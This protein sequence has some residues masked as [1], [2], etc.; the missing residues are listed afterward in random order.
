M[1]TYSGL[2]GGS[3]RRV[4]GS[5]AIVLAAFWLPT[6]GT[7]GLAQVVP[8]QAL[9]A[10]GAPQFRVDPFWP[11][12]LPNRWSMQQVTGISVDTQDTVW[13]LNRPNAPEM[14]EISAEGT[15]SPTLCCIKGPELIQLDQQGNVL[16]SWGGAGHPKW[17]TNSQTVIADS[18]GNIWISGTAA[19]DSI[20][21]YSREGTVLWDFDHRPPAEAAEMPEIN[22]ETSF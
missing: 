12:P 1:N 14:D 8:G 18:K 5:L 15:P 21:K 2:T 17:P 4:A 13:F 9:D 11:K 10:S 20:I 22:L 7:T 16:S 19:Q 3:Y 6:P